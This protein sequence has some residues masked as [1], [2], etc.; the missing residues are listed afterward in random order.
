MQASHTRKIESGKEYDYLFPKAEGGEIMLKWD[1]DVWDTLGQIPKIV[2]DTLDDTKGIAKL[3]KGNTLYETCEN[4]WDFVYHHIQYAHDEEGVEQL[5]RPARSWMDRVRGVDCDCYTVF[6]SSILTNLSIPHTYR[7]AKYKNKKYYQHIYPIVPLTNGKYITID[8]VVDAY[9]Y[10]EPFTQK[11]DT[12]MNLSYLNGI[13][14]EQKDTSLMAVNQHSDVSHL[15]DFE[16]FDGLGKGKFFQKIGEGLKKGLHVANMVN[17][18]MAVIRLGVLASLKLNLFGISRNIRW[19][20]LNDEQAK[21][22]GL[23]L[24]KLGHLRKILKKIEDIFYGAGGKP[25]N[26]KKE[27]LTSKGNRDKAVP[28]TGLG[29]TD[30]ING[31]DNYDENTPLKELLSGVFEEES[32][33]SETGTNGLGVIATSAA[34]ASVSTILGTIA[35]LIKKIGSIK[36]GGGGALTNNGGG[37]NQD[38]NTN[39]ATNNSNES[40][41][42]N[43]NSGGGGNTRQTTSNRT[44]APTNTNTPSTTNSA[45]DNTTDDAGNNNSQAPQTFSQKAKAWVHEHPVKATFIGLATAGLFTFGIVELHQHMKKKKQKQQQQPALSGTPRKKRRGKKH[46]GKG[47]KHH[48]KPIALL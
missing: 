44:P 7:I 16:D 33:H 1:A 3:L 29:E 13:E 41:M 5:R 18:G 45:G 38:E 39:T 22:Q 36:Q 46:K 19:A 26:L 40:D 11:H 37:G 17:P 30:D 48:K 42:S 25:E 34:I 20:Y 9:N 23:D 28:L 24:G 6:I 8:C 2:Y 21:Q 32:G 47:K 4:I 35:A 12:P 43:N 10:E 15:P 27:I 14:T 31:V